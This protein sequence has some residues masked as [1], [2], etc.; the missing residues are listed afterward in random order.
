MVKIFGRGKKDEKDEEF[1]TDMALTEHSRQSPMSDEMIYS[2]GRSV[3]MIMDPEVTGILNADG[4]DQ[5]NALIP[6]FSHL[7]RTTNIDKKQAE[8]LTLDYEYLSLI[9]KLNMNEDEYENVGWAMLESLKIFAHGI[10]SDAFHG[11]KGKLVTEQIKI[12]RTELEK[13]KKGL[14]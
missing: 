11:W 13:K 14:F 6:A 1:G 2:L 10:T 8:L 7:N 5:F 9:H 4:N 12:I 3:Y